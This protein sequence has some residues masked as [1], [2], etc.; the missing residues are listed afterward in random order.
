MFK[1]VSCY[2]DSNQR[3]NKKI[4]DHYKTNKTKFMTLKV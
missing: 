4:K 1:R 3:Y 2:T